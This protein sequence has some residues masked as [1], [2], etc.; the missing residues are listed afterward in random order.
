MTFFGLYRDI[1][2]NVIAGKIC[3]DYAFINAEVVSNLHL[4]FT[5][6][7]TLGNAVLS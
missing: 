2:A 7:Q 5:T 3:P 6:C 1:R 4:S